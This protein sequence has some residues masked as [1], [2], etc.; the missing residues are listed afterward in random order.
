MNEWIDAKK[1]QTR[2]IL[3]ACLG[4]L[5]V[6]ADPT[7]YRHQ[8]WTRDFVLATMPVLLEEGRYG[9]IRTHLENLSIRQ[10]P[11]GQVPILFLDATWPFLIEKL[12]RTWRDQK[13]S[14]ML[15]RWFQGELWNLTPGTRDSEIL[16]VIGM[17]EYADRSRDTTLLEEYLPNIQKALG[18]VEEH[19]MREGLVIGCDWRDTMHIELGDKTLLTNNALLYHAYVLL[20]DTAKANQLRRR[21]LEVFFADGQCIDYP[22]SARFDPLGGAFAVLFD[23]VGSEYYPQIAQGFTS[24]DSPHGVTIRCIHNAYTFEETAIFERTNGVVIW[25]F[26]VGFFILALAKMGESVMA[27]DQFEKLSNLDGFREWYDPADGKGYGAIEQLWSTVLFLRAA[28]V[29]EEIGD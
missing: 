23:V 21:I 9:I 5:G 3:D 16:Y 17:L 26:V 20:K 22:E 2:R 19:L 14:F 1:G 6:W 4:K 11:N 29:I 15:G 18:Y 12:R 7:R 10:R 24:V 13:M 25:P 8:N 28:Q 27:R